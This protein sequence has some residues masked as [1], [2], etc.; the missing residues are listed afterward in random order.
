[1]SAYVSDKEYHREKRGGFGSSESGE[2]WRHRVQ[3]GMLQSARL[4]RDPWI[5]TSVDMLLAAGFFS[6]PLTPST[7]PRISNGDIER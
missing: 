2:G 6:P 1:M 3:S 4:G 5:W 7:V